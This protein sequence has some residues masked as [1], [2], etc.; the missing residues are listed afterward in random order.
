V[1]AARRQAELARRAL[2]AQPLAGPQFW[3]PL[4][5]VEAQLA[6]AGLS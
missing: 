5:A 1:A 3:R 4:K 2:T 6:K